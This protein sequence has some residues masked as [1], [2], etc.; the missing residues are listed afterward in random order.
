MVEGYRY[1]TQ[2]IYKTDINKERTKI[3]F[4]SYVVHN[5]NITANC[6]KTTSKSLH[7]NLCLD[8][9]IKNHKTQI[10]LHKSPSGSVSKAIAKNK[11]L[12]A[13]HHRVFKLGKMNG[14]N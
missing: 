2:K 6:L 11:R 5:K 9:N 4:I 7:Q 8:Y 14:P 12:Q 3:E 10:K 1:K 13:I